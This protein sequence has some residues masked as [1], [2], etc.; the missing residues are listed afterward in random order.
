MD[1]NRLKFMAEV[2][3]EDVGQYADMRL[4]MIIRQAVMTA[5]KA[6]LSLD[7]AIEILENEALYLRKRIEEATK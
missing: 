1:D 4:R 7:E 5:T 6:E 3:A 2:V